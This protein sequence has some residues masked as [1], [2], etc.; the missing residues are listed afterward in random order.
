MGGIK[1]LVFDFGGVVADLTRERAIAAFEALG[2]SDADTMLSAYKQ[3]GL[4]L[5]IEDGSLSKDAFC[6]ALSAR[7]GRTLDNAQVGAAWYAFVEGVPAYKLAELERLRRDYRVYI[8]S[9]TNP[10]VVD[11]MRSPAFTPEGRALSDFVDKLYTSC[12]IGA[13]KPDAKIFDAVI[14]D[15]ALR[16]QETL[17][18]DDGADNIAQAQA[19]GFFTYC[20]KNREDW[21]APIRRL[22]AAAS[23]EPANPAR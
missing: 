9:N 15:A 18:V 2:V 11:W 12:E 22:L 10:Y 14:A 1:N 13:C 21:R 16:P 20:P 19:M 6:A 17:F 5:G 7:V 3:T 8:L 23:D 4:Y